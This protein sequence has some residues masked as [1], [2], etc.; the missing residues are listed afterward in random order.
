MGKD[1]E[2]EVRRDIDI[3]PRTLKRGSRITLAELERLAPG[4]AGPLRRTGIIRQVGESDRERLQSK[5]DER[6][7]HLHQAA[8]ADNARLA[9]FRQ[10]K[11]GSDES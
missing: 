6:K 9:Q 5:R 8:R 3:G 11:R 10:E 2:F 4:K 7:E 1:G